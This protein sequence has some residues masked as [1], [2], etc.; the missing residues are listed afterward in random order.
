MP[1]DERWIVCKLIFK[2]EESFIDYLK[3]RRKT[4]VEIVKEH[5][6]MVIKASLAKAQ[7]PR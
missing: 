6:D 3:S 5:N 1:D 4:A 2:S 7:K